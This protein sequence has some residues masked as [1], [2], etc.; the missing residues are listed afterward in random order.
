[1]SLLLGDDQEFF[2]CFE[3]LLDVLA[4]ALHL[5]EADVLFSLE[6]FCHQI[7][8]TNQTENGDVV[9]FVENSESSENLVESRTAGGNIVN[10]EDVLFPN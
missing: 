8:S 4:A 7:L 5:A 2:T 1:M 6:C 9:V 10:D 3:R